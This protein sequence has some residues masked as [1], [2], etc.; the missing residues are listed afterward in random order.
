MHEPR[1]EL[2]PEVGATG[3]LQTHLEVDGHTNL[4]VCWLTRDD[5]DWSGKEHTLQGRVAS[6]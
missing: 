3:L 4:H 5:M 1:Y 6:V 2:L